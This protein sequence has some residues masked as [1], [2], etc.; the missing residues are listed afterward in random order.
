MNRSTWII[1]A[2]LILLVIYGSYYAGTHSTKSTLKPTP[3]P[4]TKAEVTKTPE[5][6]VSGTVTP[7][8]TTSVTGTITPTQTPTP[9]VTSTPTPTKGFV[10]PNIRKVATP[11]TA[12]FKIPNIRTK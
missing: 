12:P 4:T 3:T 8:P 2:I 11:T 10:I 1:L 5:A 9:T 7:E 6:S